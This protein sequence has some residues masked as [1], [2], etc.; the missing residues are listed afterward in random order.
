MVDEIK[1]YFTPYKYG[2]PVLQGSGIV[3]TYNSMA[4]DCP[5]V[6]FHNNRYYMLHVG[7]DGKGYQT[8]LSTST[9]LLH[10]SD[11]KVIFPR[12]QE[13]RWDSVG[14]AGLWILRENSLK[15]HSSLKKI[16]GKYWM[17]YHSYPKE[18]YEAGSA[19]IGL[20]WTDDEELL[21]WNRLDEPILSWKDGENWERGGLYKGCLVEL[22]GKYYLFYNAKQRDE[23][24]W[25]EQIGV[26]FSDDMF[27]WK[28]Y[29]QNPIIR[30]SPGSWDSLFCAD[31]FV[32]WDNE[33][34][35]MYYYGCNG[36]NAEDGIAVSQD[37]IHWEKVKQP[38]LKH[39]N[40]GE[41][42]CYYAH[43]PC[44]IEKDGVLYHFY[45]G[46]REGRETDPCQNPATLGETREFRCITVACSENIFNN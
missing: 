3:G 7:F 29:G 14:V 36:I 28:R 41:I 39:G 17:V 31:P 24:P 43:K 23:S 40:S 16:D 44:V 38:V 12:K 30:N 33:K 9:D 42:D 46:V 22:H 21:K 37:L 35:I 34:W 45:C 5:F 18:G 2:K 25:N 27:H 15:G 20:A 8:A 19:Q 10:W 13:E 1:K 11:G 26:A 32:V 6:F 4:V